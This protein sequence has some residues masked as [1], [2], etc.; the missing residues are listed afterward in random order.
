MAN[1]FEGKIALVTGGGSGIGRASALAFSREGARVVIADI[2]VSGGECTASLIEEAGGEADF[3][4]TDVSREPEVE[5]MIARIVAAWGRL[6]IAH[7]NA[8][9]IGTPALTA[10]STE[11][12]WDLVVG[13]NLKGTW[14]CLKHEIRRMVAQGSGAIVNT[15]SIAG[16]VALP[17]ISAYIASKHGILG[18]TKVAALECA[19]KGIRVNAVCPGYID[20]P[21]ARRFVGDTPEALAQAGST[22]PLGRLGKPE[23]VAEAAVWLCSEASSFV[24]GHTLVLDGG[25]TAQ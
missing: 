7:N 9:E 14:L 22:Q 5:A 13:T 2:D 21:M 11:E 3:I 1:R 10:E 8:G 17:T 19:A 18:L 20:T 4:R 16:L 6:D 24:T 23:E 15:A 25:Y 12:N